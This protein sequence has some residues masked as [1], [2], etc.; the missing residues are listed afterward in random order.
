MDLFL[1][2]AKS[3]LIFLALQED[4]EMIPVKKENSALRASRKRTML[5]IESVQETK[6]QRCCKSKCLKSTLTLHDLMEARKE[7]WVLDQE[8]RG[9][10]QLHFFSF[11]QK[12]QNGKRTLV[13]LVNEKR[14]A[15]RLGCL[16]MGFHTEGKN[17]VWNIYFV[18]FQSVTNSTVLSISRPR[19]IRSSRAFKSVLNQ[20]WLSFFAFLGGKKAGTPFLS[21]IQVFMH[22]C[23]YT[24]VL[25][26]SSKT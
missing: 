15:K 20:T 19:S 26:K 6:L 21:L 22:C 24:C 5:S 4:M 25:N 18:Q 10:W 17:G 23:P 16:A 2:I 12:V 7:Y 3:N 14:C 11:A 13:Y 8:E 1:T 9:Q